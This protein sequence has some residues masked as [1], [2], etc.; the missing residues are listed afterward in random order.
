MKTSIIYFN[1]L[2]LIA[3][4]SCTSSKKMK[5]SNNEEKL[6]S[7]QNKEEIIQKILIDKNYTIPEKLDYTINSVNLVENIFEINV[8]YIGGCGEHSFEL[9]FNQMYA[10]SLPVQATLYLKHNSTNETCAQEINK[11]LKYFALNVKHPV[12]KIVIC[13]IYSFDS[14]FTYEY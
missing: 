13:K 14:K 7:T 5:N 1:I 6:K 3:I 12:N 2:L 4:F 11:T 8:T 10:K 9:L